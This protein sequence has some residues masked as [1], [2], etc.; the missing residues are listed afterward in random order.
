[1]EDLLVIDTP[2]LVQVIY[3]PLRSRILRH[4]VTPMSVKQ[5]ANELRTPVSRLYYH[6]HLL[7]E[8]GL[9]AIADQQL[10]RTKLERVYVSRY[11]SYKLARSLQD[12][13]VA[14]SNGLLVGQFEDIAEEYMDAF[15]TWD[16]SVQAYSSVRNRSKRLRPD[17]LRRY[18]ARAAALFEEYFGSEAPEDPD[19][20]LFG[21]LWVVTPFAAPPRQDSER[22][23]TEPRLD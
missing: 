23:T 18:V 5:L 2:E 3:D 10:S 15:A 7:E 19:G 4:L 12:L 22:P 1:M 13:P 17:R 21:H 16:D 8:H 20:I 6:V 9:V 11:H 14:S